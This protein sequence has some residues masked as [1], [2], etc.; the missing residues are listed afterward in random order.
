GQSGLLPGIS[1]AMSQGPQRGAT[2]NGLLQMSVQLVVR[3]FNILRLV[4]ADQ[5]TQGIQAYADCGWQRRRRNKLLQL[6]LGARQILVTR[7]QDRR[8]PQA[9][10]YLDGQGNGYVGQLLTCGR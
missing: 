8:R 9:G 3:L 10:I 1:K 6:L 2:E 4:A 7:Q 5:G